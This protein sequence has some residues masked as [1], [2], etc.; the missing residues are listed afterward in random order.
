MV[1]QLINKL[2]DTAMSVGIKTK[3]ELISKIH[4]LFSKLKTHEN[5]QP[6]K[7]VPN[8]MGI[9][10]ELHELDKELEDRFRDDW[11]NLHGY[12]IEDKSVEG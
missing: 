2:G 11:L 1:N 8:C 4:I 12:T 7:M 10:D 9:Y 6:E 5:Y 3:E